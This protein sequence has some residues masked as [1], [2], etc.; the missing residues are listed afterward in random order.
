MDKQHRH[1]WETLT[2]KDLVCHGCNTVSS[3]ETL[4]I[5]TAA[6]ARRQEK[7]DVFVDQLRNGSL[8]KVAR[9]EAYGWVMR[10]RPEAIK[11]KQEAL[12]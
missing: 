6:E 2:K 5:N 8:K 4:I 3:I 11:S 1:S 7:I 10:N 9:E 12:L